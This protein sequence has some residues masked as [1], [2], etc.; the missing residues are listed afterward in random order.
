M[1]MQDIELSIRKLWQLREAGVGVAIDDFGT[2]YSSLKLLS[3][4]PVDT[5][6]IDR[7]FIQSI[8]DTPNVMT[9][10]A[11]IVSLARA[12]D[13]QTVAEGVETAEQLTM[14]R[15]INCDQAQGF[16]LGRPTAAA[17]VPA[18]IRRLS[19]EGKRMVEW[20]DPLVMGYM[21]P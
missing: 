1:L 3:R 12:F 7:S 14:L 13:M 6:K 20:L 8:S 18:V 4:L 5:L 17:E 9:L 16:Y 21:R 11:T 15:V 10:V 2:G 19:Q